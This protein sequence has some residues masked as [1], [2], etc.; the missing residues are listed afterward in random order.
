M[1]KWRITHAREL[2]QLNG[3]EIYP[4]DRGWSTKIIVKIGKKEKVSKDNYIAPTVKVN[5]KWQIGYEEKINDL[6][7]HYAAKIKKKLTVHNLGDSGSNTGGAVAA[8]LPLLITPKDEFLACL[9]LFALVVG[10]T[11]LV[12]VIALAIAAYKKNR[13]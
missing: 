13:D 7:L 2:C 12:T 8:G 6:W 9:I 11:G 1:E 4:A 3:I 5:G 10:L